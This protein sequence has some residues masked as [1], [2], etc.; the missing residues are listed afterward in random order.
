MKKDE[1]HKGDLGKDKESVQQNI[2][3]DGYP[4]PGNSAFSGP[5]QIWLDN[6]KQF[7][8]APASTALLSVY[9]MIGRPQYKPVAEISDS[10]IDSE[11]DN[12]ISV[13]KK[14]NV[15]VDAICEVD[16]RELYRFITEELF[17]YQTGDVRAE[18]VKQ[19]FI[20][21]EFHPNHD[22][23]V[24]NHAIDLIESLLNKENDWMPDFLGLSD[25][26]SNGD[27]SM[28]RTDAIRKMTDFRDAF[29]EFEVELFEITNVQIIGDRAQ[30]VFSARYSAFIEG[31][32]EKIE[33]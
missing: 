30:V 22:Y 15:V 29:S 11:L 6:L 28:A 24:R 33:A 21:E 23:D 3:P 7:Q 32:D 27:N 12:L 20:Y 10:N 31:S 17:L 8:S 9:D 1:E 18:G 5:H 2:G 4:P 16:D 14:Y 19:Y 13:M 26:L 25:V